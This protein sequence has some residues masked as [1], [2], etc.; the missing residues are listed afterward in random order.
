VR[1]PVADDDR[2]RAE[3]LRDGDDPLR[4]LA[5]LHACARGQTGEPFGN[6]LQ[7]PIGIC[8]LARVDHGSEI[9]VRSHQQDH[10]IGFT[11][12]G[13]PGRVIHGQVR[14]CGGIR[15]YQDRRHD[16]ASS[17]VRNENARP[18]GPSI[19]TGD[20]VDTYVVP[21]PAGG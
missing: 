7:V 8:R 2:V 4:R 1:P 19:R 14:R 10:Q 6:V 3:L 13:E 18:S 16:V 11:V 15:S 20:H 5:V 12:P 17:F 21:A 9:A